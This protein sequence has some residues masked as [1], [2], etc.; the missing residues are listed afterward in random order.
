MLVCLLTN[1]GFDL[2]YLDMYPDPYRQSCFAAYNFSRTA[3]FVERDLK[4]HH[5]A[6]TWEAD[7]NGTMKVYRDGLLMVTVWPSCPLS[8]SSHLSLLPC[9]GWRSVRAQS[10][11]S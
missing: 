7:K 4:W 2:Q 3:N 11:N 5:L 1:A 8:H 9:F 10:R 6:V